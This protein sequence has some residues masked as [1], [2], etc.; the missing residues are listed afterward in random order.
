[1]HFRGREGGGTVARM[2]VQSLF[3]ILL[4][5]DL[6]RLVAFY[7]AAMDAVVGYRFTDDNGADAYVSLTIGA[8]TLAI[9]RDAAATDAT[10]DRA[11]LWFYVDDVDAAFA[12]MVDAGAVTVQEPTDM[13]WGERVAQMRDPD[14]NLV[15]LGALASA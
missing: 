6:P 13:P 11:A 8:A 10:G 12:R 4:T 1:M 3:P 15:N 2:A 7:E 5:G 9:G 14:G